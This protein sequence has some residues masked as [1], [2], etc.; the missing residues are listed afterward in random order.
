MFL[1]QYHSDNGSVINISEQQASSFAKDISGDFN[2]IHDPGSKSY[3]VPGDLLFALVLVKY[4]LSPQMDF[5]FTGM[6]RNNV[7]LIF[8][9]EANSEISICD[10]KGKSYLIVRRHGTAVENVELT[11]NLI[12]E[13]VAFSGQNF[14]HILMPLMSEH[15]VMINP[16]RPL[17]I[18]DSMSFNLE[19]LN[20]SSIR[21][22]LAK[23]ALEIT[24][25][26]AEARLFFKAS[27]DGKTMGTG[28]KKLILSGLRPYDPA[29]MERL[30]DEYLSRKAAYESAHE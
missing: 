24:G 8:P 10:S 7:G 11:E 15:R 19:R 16:A 17:V 25:K 20:Y 21:L 22:E 27:A 5:H 28:Y 14:P 29:T 6:V 30:R 4:G 23:T 13:Y 2:P 1:D 9:P 12:R 26:R 18:Y 3:C